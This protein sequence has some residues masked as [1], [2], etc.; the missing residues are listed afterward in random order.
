MTDS[1]L[2]EAW[3]HHTE[4]EKLDDFSEDRK[5]MAAEIRLVLAELKAAREVV[6]YATNI[7][8][9][10]AHALPTCYS[11]KCKCWHRALAESIANYDEARQE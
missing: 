6:I 8:K 1:K 10:T 2:L 9:F 3:C 5:L 7:L 11:N 4:H